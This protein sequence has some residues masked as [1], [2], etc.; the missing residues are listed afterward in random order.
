MTKQCQD[1]PWNAD[2]LFDPRRFPLPFREARKLITMRQD[3][4]IDEIIVSLGTRQEFLASRDV[5]A[6]F[7]PFGYHPILGQPLAGAPRGEE[8]TQLLN[9]AKLL[10]FLRNYPWE[11]PRLRM[12]MAMGC[13]A[14]I[15]TESFDDTAPF[16]PSE[17]FNMSP[18]QYE[19]LP[20]LNPYHF[21][22]KSYPTSPETGQCVYCGRS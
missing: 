15:V 16:R 10:L 17:H 13:K 8:H 2:R 22:K 11:M 14:P 19:N 20:I 1:Q 7:M 9:R 4:L 3:H 18:T 12:M 6:T 5:P 21:H